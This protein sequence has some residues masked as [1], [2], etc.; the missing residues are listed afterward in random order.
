VATEYKI[1]LREFPKN[2][3]AFRVLSRENE[4]D[5]WAQAYYPAELRE[6]LHMTE[7]S[8]VGHPT[9]DDC[10]NAANQAI[11]TVTDYYTTNSTWDDVP[12]EEAD[13]GF[14]DVP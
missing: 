11:A 4:T 5:E 7:L 6:Y 12:P 13:P 9:R 8:E 14:T 2:S 3:W 1:Q 10:I